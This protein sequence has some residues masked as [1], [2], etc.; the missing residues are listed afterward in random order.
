MKNFALIGLAG[1]VAK[2]HIKCIS[3]LKG[4][5]VAALDEHDNVGFIDSYFPKCNFF[6]K[7]SEFFRFVKKKQIDYVVVCSPSY[8]HFNHIKLSLLSGSNVIVEKPPV[9]KYED[10]KKI[11]ILEKKTKKRCYCIFQLRL[12]KKL[13]KLKKEVDKKNTKQKVVIKYYTFRGKWYFKSWKNNKKYSGGLLVNIGIHFF[14]ILLW[15]F[16]DFKKIQF[17]KKNDSTVEGII[18]LEKANAKWTV[19]V[20]NIKEKSK[21]LKSKY[22]RIMKINK[23]IINFDKFND[24]H[25]TNY[26]EIIKG[27]F[28]ISEFVKIIKLL[29]VLK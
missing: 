14:D 28:H 26:K 29:S 6:K 23:K 19:S 25:L 1:F 16:G 8:L 3:D 10:Y 5:L 2:K 13:K 18:Y 9:I 12:D 17:L 22:Y 7:E 15:I 24:L 20:E 11:Q 27:K 4:N 21:K